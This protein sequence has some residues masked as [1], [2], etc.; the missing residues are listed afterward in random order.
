MND[1]ANKSQNDVRIAHRDERRRQRHSTLN[2]SHTHEKGKKMK[3]SE[4]C[5]VNNKHFNST[6]F[7]MAKKDAENYKI[8]TI[9]IFSNETRLC[10][11]KYFDRPN[12]PEHCCRCLVGWT[13]LSLTTAAQNRWIRGGQTETK[14]EKRREKNCKTI[15]SNICLSFS[16]YLRIQNAQKKV[17]RM[18]DTTALN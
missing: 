7:R 1:C 17:W 5:F 3:W 14:C 8:N 18:S 6:L 13:H 11:F 4:E 16:V 10:A 15:I 12:N 2:P 9:L